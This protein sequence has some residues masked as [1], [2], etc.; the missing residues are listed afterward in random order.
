MQTTKQQILALLKRTGGAT[1]DEAAGALSIASMTARQ[2]LVSLERDGILEVSAV[3]R[4]TGRPHFTYRLTPKGENLFPRR[5][6]LLAC[7]LV[8]EVGNVQAEDFRSRSPEEKRS[9]LVERVVDRLI[10]DHRPLVGGRT[11]ERRVAAVTDLLQTLG[12]FAEWRRLDDCY[13]IRDYNCI[14]YNVTSET[15]GCEWHLRLLAGL[16]D[17]PVNHDVLREGTASCCRYTVSLDG[18]GDSIL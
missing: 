15:D 13:E 6:D 4:A 10:E 5:Y 7:L 14:F 12:G 1:V 8:D 9:L 18:E 3:K 16:L 11:I 17:R 2:H